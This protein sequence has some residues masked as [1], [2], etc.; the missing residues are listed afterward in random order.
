MS[1][2]AA[3]MAA[4]LLFGAAPA[5]AQLSLSGELDL[6]ATQRDERG[7]NENFRGDSPFNQVRLRLFAQHWINDRIGVFSELLFD[8]GA[9]EP[10]V[11]GAYVV[12]N[13]IAGL[14][15]VNARVGM[16]PSPLG[17]FGLRDTY[18]NANPVVGVP[19]LWQHRNEDLIRRR[20]SNAI[21]LPIFYSAC[22]HVQWELMGDVGPLEYS[23]GATTGSFSNMA[24]MEEDGIGW[25]VRLGSEPI[26]GIRF[27]ANLGVAPWIGG[28]VRDNLIGA[29]SYPGAPEDYLQ[30]VFGYDV[31]VSRGKWRLISEAFTSAWEVPLIAEDLEAWSGYG[32]ASFDFL[33]A[34]QAGTRVGVMR[35]GEISSTN[36]GLGARTGWDDDTLQIES[37]LSYRLAREII[38]RGNWQHT[39]FTTGPEQPIDLLGLQ[40]KAVF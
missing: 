24:A 13:R 32:E 21:G 29:R 35:F 11:N 16:A 3:L 26:P 27:G 22:W 15:Q 20:A 30:T 9:T 38:V 10:R 25:T 14:E 8:M 34:W 19:L 37:A 28:P 31:E 6:L 4:L 36:D 17:S 40:V 39:R 12:V 1:R 2:R 7:L 23:V 18:F 33:P 5:G